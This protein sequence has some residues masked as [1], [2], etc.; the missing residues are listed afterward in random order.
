METKCVYTLSMMLLISVFLYGCI[1]HLNEN[2]IKEHGIKEI[3]M[4]AFI[5]DKEK[6][7][8][9]FIAIVTGS[10]S[11]GYN[12]A[13]HDTEAAL[14]DVRNKIVQIGGNA[15]KLIDIDSTPMSTTVIAEALWCNFKGGS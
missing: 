4:V 10:N 3:K 5:K 2:G 9:N 12:S 11:L 8:C 14:N 1:I 7:K 13:Q 15:A 6:N